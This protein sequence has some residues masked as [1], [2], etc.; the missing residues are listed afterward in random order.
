MCSETLQSSNGKV[1]KR[2]VT[3]KVQCHIK[4]A[5]LGAVPIADSE[6][7]SVI[8][9]GTG[10]VALSWWLCGHGDIDAGISADLGGVCVL[11]WPS[12]HT[13]RLMN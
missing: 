8:A 11:D 12:N 10:A 9:A 1:G 2:L 7:R 4:T 3:T 13:M 6:A 5:T